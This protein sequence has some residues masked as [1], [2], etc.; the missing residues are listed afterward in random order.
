MLAN[1]QCHDEQTFQNTSTDGL[2]VFINAKDTF[3]F[4]L[5]HNKLQE[6]IASAVEETAKVNET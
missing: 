2:W 6:I 5:Y 3:E 4:Y 1:P